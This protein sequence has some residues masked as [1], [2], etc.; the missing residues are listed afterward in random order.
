VRFDTTLN[1][2]WACLGLLALIGTFRICLRSKKESG[3]SRWLLFIGVAS[4]VAALFP[5]VSATDD[6]LR[7]DRFNSQHATPDGTKRHTKAD[8]LVRLFET[9]DTPLVCRVAGISLIFVFVAFVPA[10]F[11]TGI[12]RSVPLAS[13]RSPPSCFA[14]C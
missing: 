12:D 3:K 11:E 9:L 14:A 4:I 8:D 7:I 5:Y 1:L 13:V 6:V 10:Y 2:L